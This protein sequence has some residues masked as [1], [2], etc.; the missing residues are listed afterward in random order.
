MG[1]MVF[2]LAL[3]CAGFFLGHW[4]RG[5]EAPIKAGLSA[6]Q[7]FQPTSFG[8]LSVPSENIYS[9]IYATLGLKT[10]DTIH[11]INGVKVP[12]G[13]LL[14]VSAYKSGK[15]CIQYKRDHANRQVCLHKSEDGE[16]IEDT[17]LD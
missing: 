6:V 15:L 4:Y 16:Q 9:R 3:V 7:K 10:N 14:L 5:S 8:D 11:A 1:K 12:D 13:F 2:G 17:R